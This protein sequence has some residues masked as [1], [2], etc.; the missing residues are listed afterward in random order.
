MF[1]SNFFPSPPVSFLFNVDIVFS[2]KKHKANDRKRYDESNATAFSS[3]SNDRFDTKTCIQINGKLLASCNASIG[4]SHW[5]VTIWTIVHDD[6]WATVYCVNNTIN[7]AKQSNYKHSIKT[8]RSKCAR[9]LVESANDGYKKT[10]NHDNNDNSTETGHPMESTIRTIDNSYNANPHLVRKQFF[11]S[12]LSFHWYL[13]VH[14]LLVFRTSSSMPSLP[15]QTTTPKPKP[16][17]TTRRP[18][19]STT[20]PSWWHPE[21]TPYHRPGYF[22]PQTSEN[23][24]STN[25]AS[26]QPLTSK[27]NSKP[28]IGDLSVLSIASFPYFDYF[29][30]SNTKSFARKPEYELLDQ[31]PAELLQ[32]I[33][34]E[35]YEQHKGTDQE[36][37]NDFRRIYDD[38]FA[39]V[40]VFSPITGKKRVPPT[41]PYVLFL[42]FYDL[43]K[44]EAKRLGLQEFTVW[45]R[46]KKKLIGLQIIAFC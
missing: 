34:N 8:S 17:P 3:E 35:P 31:Y 19:V 44:R 28:Q 33:E 6:R 13:Y 22:A 20:T 45:I 41:R 2:T 11:L 15:T 37:V 27:P 30:P 38:F 21:T 32:D 36:I 5:I 9:D 25:G 39:R 10:T 14:I 12:G 42:I 40:R 16:R 24:A 1:I 43:C 4:I 7:I 23:S 29:V 46:R 26:R 18:L